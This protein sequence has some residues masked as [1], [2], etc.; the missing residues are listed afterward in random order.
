MPQNP[1]PTRRS[2]LQTLGIGAGASLSGVGLLSGTTSVAGETS[3]TTEPGI[4]EDFED[5]DLDEYTFDYGSSNTSII[6]TPTYNGSYALE[7][8]DDAHLYRTQFPR[9]PSQGE[10]FSCHTQGS[11]GPFAEFTYGLQDANNFYAVRIRY[12]VDKISILKREAGSWTELTGSYLGFSFLE[13]AWYEMEVDWS[14]SGDH[15][16]TVRGN[17]DS[18]TISVTD[19]TWASG[20]I[21]FLTVGSSSTVARYD[22][23]TKPQRELDGLTV[24]DFEDGD[25]AEYT[26]YAGSSGARVTDTTSYTRDRALEL[27]DADVRMVDPGVTPTPGQGDTVSSRI[28]VGAGDPFAYFAYGVQ[29]G[30]NFYAARISTDMDKISILKIQDG[31]ATELSGVYSA[32][33]LVQ[34]VWYKVSIAW[35]VDGDHELTV[36]GNGDSVTCSTVDTTWNRGG[37]GFLQSMLS[38]TGTSY[39]DSVQ[40][41]PVIGNFEVALD[42]WS[43]TGSSTLARKHGDQEPAAVTRD[44]NTLEVSISSESNPS[45]ECQER[46]NVAN[47][48]KTPYL[49]VDVLPADVQN[50]DSHV[51]FQLHY[52]HSDPGGVVDSQ[53]FTVEQTFGGVLAWDLRDLSDQELESSD[54]IE[55][56]WYP[57]DHPPGSGFDYNGR[58]L[59]DNVRLASDLNEYSDGAFFHKHRELELARGLQVD[60]VV[61]SQTDTTQ[62]GV[63]QYYDGTEVAYTTEK[64]ADGVIEQTVDGETFR[65]TEDSQ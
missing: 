12:D 17:G 52:H 7:S 55:I 37:I 13:D 56:S 11:G 41:E 34:D 27:K 26:F 19:T 28:R 5:G 42:G 39:Y 32:S 53:E 38:S 6:T 46:V 50:S 65:W 31:S 44:D 36:S 3:T 59:V 60:Q 2:L 45:I 30:Y 48:E 29:D 9:A 25:L 51:T 61:Q 54:R 35:S 40:L 20:G 16:F 64:I 18:A 58:V 57:T 47:C 23:A 15:T 24:D 4:I 21:G 62:D 22:Y 43:S 1:Q 10:L 33:P 49:L 63:Y 8:Q 14:E